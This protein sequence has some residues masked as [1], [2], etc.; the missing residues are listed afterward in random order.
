MY[1]EAVYYTNKSM[2]LH[3]KTANF[4]SERKKL[5]EKVEK[6]KEEYEKKSVIKK[7]L[8]SHLKNVFEK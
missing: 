5:A 3:S 1:G 4:K 2:N 8:K 6:K 7:R